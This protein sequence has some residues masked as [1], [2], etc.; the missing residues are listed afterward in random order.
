MIS[1]YQGSITTGEPFMDYESVDCAD[2]LYDAN[3]GV[4]MTLEKTVS[5]SCYLQ[6]LDVLGMKIQKITSKGFNNANVEP[7][8]IAYNETSEDYAMLYA[9][10][11]D[12]VP[13]YVQTFEFDGELIKFGLRYQDTN[14]VYVPNGSVKHEKNLFEIPGTKLFVYGY[15]SGVLA[16]F[17]TGYRGN[18]SGYL[19]ISTGVAYTG[20]SCEVVIKGHI[21]V[22]TTLPANWLG[23]KLYVVDPTREY[24]ESLSL[25]STHG[26]F[27]GTCLDPTRV[28]LGL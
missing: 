20:Q 19:G 22:G 5:G 28:L 12:N 7:L 18:L 1:S 10:G 16:T 23:K 21:Y 8:G 14:G 26:V 2:M 11:V 13:V 15:D 6:V 25:S 17:E 9:T 24:P 3:N 27:L 4:V